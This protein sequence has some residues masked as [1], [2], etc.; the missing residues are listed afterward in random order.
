MALS[1]SSPPP[2]QM[3]KRDKR[4]K[5]ILEKL[6]DMITTFSKD[7]TQHYRAQLQ[8]LQVDMNLILRADPYENAPLDDDPQKIEDMVDALTGGHI[9]GG[10]AAREDFFALAGRRYYEYCQE[11]NKAQEKRD[12]DLTMLKVNFNYRECACAS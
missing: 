9:A 10:K 1:H 7:Q 6:D 4:R 2:Q 11:I 8:A 12:A 5:N 3:T